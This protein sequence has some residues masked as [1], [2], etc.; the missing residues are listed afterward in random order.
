[1]KLRDTLFICAFIGALLLWILE[2]RRVGFSGSYDLLLLALV[3]LFGFQFFR[4][5]D[6]QKSKNMSPTIK[7]MIDKRKQDAQKK[8]AK[9]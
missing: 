5:R 9:K 1:M 8:V 7:Q 2:I 6:Q 4:V 3:F